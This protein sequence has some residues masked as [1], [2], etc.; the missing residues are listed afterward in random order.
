MN[1]HNNKFV[2]ENFTITSNLDHNNNADNFI[3]K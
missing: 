2:Q 3:F 1:D